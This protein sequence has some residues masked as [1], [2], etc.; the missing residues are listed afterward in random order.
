MDRRNIGTGDRNLRIVNAFL[1]I[2]L[3]IAG[4]FS[5]KTALAVTS[6]SVY[7]L[8]TGIAGICPVYMMFGFRTGGKK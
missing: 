2:I 7:M 5:D 1:L 3:S 8:L 6:V 4:F